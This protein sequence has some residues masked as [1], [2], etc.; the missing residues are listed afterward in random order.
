[1]ICCVVVLCG[2]REEAQSK[3][4]LPPHCLVED[5]KIIARQR[6]DKTRHY[7]RTQRLAS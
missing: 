6:M 4:F 5:S 7:Y 3:R 2:I 1:M